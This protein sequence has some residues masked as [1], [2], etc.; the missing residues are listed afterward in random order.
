MTLPNSFY[1]G[2]PK[3]GSSWIFALLDAHPQIFV[4]R[5]KYVQFF[6]DFYDRGTNW[7]ESFYAGAR[8]DHVALCDLTTDYLFVPEAAERLAEQIPDARI[9]FSLRDPVERDWSAYQHLLRTGQAYGPLESEIETGHRL[10]SGCSAYA[11]A[12]ERSWRLFG[13]ER[14][15]I[16][17]FDDIRD[18]PQNVADTLH[19]FL[20]VA[21]R[22][23]S[24]SNSKARNVAR[25]AR[26][27]R[28]TAILK[29]AAIA[30]RSVGMGQVLGWMKDNP[31]LDRIL[32]SRASVP[33][34]KDCPAAW[35]FLADRHEEE[36]L[37]LE[38]LLSCDLTKWRQRP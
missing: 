7:Y 36:I 24:P 15:K 13:R 2:P 31:S 29:K 9:F 6:T 17:W 26:N 20:G 38:A 22:K 21:R 18:N 16:L 23:I 37:R 35:T 5:G 10:L 30:M 25:V 1:G 19:D 34:L 14:T 27:R 11:D 4:P 12:I 3:A 28:L 8:P 33:R 32:F